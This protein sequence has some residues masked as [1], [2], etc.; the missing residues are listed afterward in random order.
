MTMGDSWS[1]NPHD[2]YK[3]PREL[4]HT[5]VEIVAKGGNLLLGIGPQGNGELPATAL[6]RL[7]ALG[8]WMRVNGSAI[9]ASRAIAPYQEGKF[10]FTQLR[11]GSVNAIRLTG[12]DEHAPPASIELHSFRPVA[13]A[14]LHVLGG[15]EPVAWQPQGSGFRVELSESVRRRVAGMPAWTLRIPAVQG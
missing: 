4:V 1:W 7:G 11:D 3:S 10:R 12:A 9:H 8:E 5:L 6:E 14:R 15:P 13:G 2:K